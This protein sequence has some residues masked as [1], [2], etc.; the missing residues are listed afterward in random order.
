MIERTI[1]VDPAV[2]V[3]PITNDRSILMI[4]TGS[5]PR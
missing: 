5:R 1:A 2:L 4:L 3:I